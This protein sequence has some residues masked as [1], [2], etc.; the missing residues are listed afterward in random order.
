[1]KTIAIIFIV[2]GI[3]AVIGFS[4]A[5]FLEI[6][7]LQEQKRDEE[8]DLNNADNQPVADED[9]DHQQASQEEF[10]L[11]A[12][13]ARLEAGAKEEGES[14]QVEEANNA[15]EEEVKAEDVFV[16]PEMI[17][18][19]EVEEAAEEQKTE[20]ANESVEEEKVESVEEPIEE[21]KT[22]TVEEVEV[23]DAEP[24][25]VEQEPEVEVKTVEN[26]N[27]VIVVKELTREIINNVPVEEKKV[28]EVKP[29]EI[30]ES[31]KS[32]IEMV[33]AELAKANREINKY[34]RTQRRMARN[35]KLLDKKAE[36]LTKLNLVL[37]SV[38]D[39]KNIDAEKKQ[40]QEDL[41]AHI[42]ELKASIKD[43]E[44][45]LEVN[46]EKNEN[47]LKMRAF[48]ENELKRLTQN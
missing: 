33:E 46:R 12:M 37:Y 19:E 25:V 1:M 39:I 8:L 24:V 42:S 9:K 32:S 16:L 7:K 40:K 13:L 48:Y 20:A 30:D 27:K 6:F 18:S 22:E 29:I 28:E 5:F 47:A 15:S 41:V 43:A 26:T 44:N 10:D 45:Y 17:E 14:E 23:V 4:V 38:T 2:L 3:F 36:D 21:D 34:E 31:A 35:Q 11:D